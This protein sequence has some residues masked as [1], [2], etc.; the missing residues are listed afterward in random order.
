MS[1]MSWVAEE[2]SVY[3]LGDLRLERRLI[4]IMET[5]A[6]QPAMRVPEVCGDWQS[7]PVTYRFFNP[8]VDEMPSLDRNK[9]LNPHRD[10]T[11]ERM[12][13]FPLV[14]CLQDTT[15]L[16]FNGQKMRGLAPPPHESRQRI[17]LHPTYVVT[18]NRIPLGTLDAWMWPRAF[19]DSEGNRPG[20]KESLRWEEGYERVAALAQQVPETRLVYVADRE[21]G[22]VSLINQAEKQ[23]CPADWLIR[24]RHDRTLKAGETLWASVKNEIPLG[25]IE[26]QFHPHQTPPGRK[27]RQ[28]VWTAEKKISNDKGGWLTVTC[29]IAMEIEPSPGVQPLEWRLLTNRKVNNLAEASEIVEWYRCCRTIKEFFNV[30]KNGCRVQAPQ[31]S[32]RLKLELAL[33]VYMVVAWRLAHLLQMGRIQPDLPANVLLSDDEWKAAYILGNK[34]LPRKVPPL[35][36]VIRRIAKLGCFSGRQ[37]NGQ[38][39]MKTLWKG[40]M[41]IRIHVESLKNLCELGIS[42]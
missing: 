9:I 10:A 35:G 15:T 40:Y 23:G 12:R 7:I 25:E 8:A 31:S 37:R 34:K 11:I 32:D 39:G 30:L 2:L 14:L 36:G 6:D 3:P 19:K 17:D 18:P 33:S 26:F 24:S 28:Q 38:P 4:R 16:R 22:I 21:A 27:V 29:M 5:V 13:Q 1:I 20:I 41:H 42:L